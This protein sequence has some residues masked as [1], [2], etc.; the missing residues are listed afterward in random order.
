MK[1][2]RVY[3]VRHGENQANLTKELSCR[4]VDY[5]LTPKGILQAQQTAEYFTQQEVW[6]V[7]ASP[8]KRARQTAEIIAGRLGLQVEVREAFRELDV[9]HLETM[10]DREA[11]WRMHFQV[12]G[13]W[14]NGHPET[15]F[16]GG[17][18]YFSAAG[19]MRRGVERALEGAD[20]Q[21]VLIAGHGG[22]FITSLTDLCPGVDFAAVS[23]ME[24]HNCAVAE[25]EMRRENGRWEG[26]LV[27]WADHSHL[28]GPAAE[29]V[30]GLPGERGHDD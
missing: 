21:G 12:I 30:S 15:R 8:L 25:I 7:Y 20:G 9:G 10:D 19:R 1:R 2:N 16:P 22:L 29:L 27:R 26:K 28:Y 3:L 6:A 11:A 5:P 14:K 24:I 13:D 17:E 4:V 18:D 23:R